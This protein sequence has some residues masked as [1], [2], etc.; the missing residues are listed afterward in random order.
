MNL[1]DYLAVSV[2][3]LSLFSVAPHKGE[4]QV[5]LDDKITGKQDTAWN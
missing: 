2:N 3:A 1:E 4:V 5:K